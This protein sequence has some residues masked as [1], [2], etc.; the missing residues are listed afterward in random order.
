MPVLPMR[1]KEWGPAGQ[2]ISGEV[3]GRCGN[4]YNGWCR[5]KKHSGTISA[6]C[7]KLL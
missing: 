2:A 6:A 5:T 7:S 4:D 1:T 3:D